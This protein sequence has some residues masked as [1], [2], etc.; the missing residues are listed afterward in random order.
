MTENPFNEQNGEAQPDFNHNE[1]ESPD[2]DLSD[3]NPDDLEF[4]AEARDVPPP[5]PT[6]AF[7]AEPATAVAAPARRGRASLKDEA[8][9]LFCGM[10]AS[11]FYSGR[12]V[13]KSA[14]ICTS[15]RREG[16]STIACGLA[17]AG[18]GPAGGERVAL[19]DFNLRNPS[20]HD[21]LG[22]RSSPG[23]VEAL[24]D[25]QS[26]ASVAQSVNNNLDVFTVG[27]IAQRSLDVLRSDAVERFFQT[28]RETYDRILVDAAPANHYPDAQVLGGVLK[29]VVLVAHCDQT[30]R[31]AIAQAKKRVEAG[32]G[33]V[34]GLVLN[35]RTYPIPGFLYRL[36]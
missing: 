18:S 2:F 32:G 16:A 27:A 21:L 1:K 26:L 24:A 30:P 36:V 34:V 22:L 23:L 35:L 29:D 4:P 13:G 7:A 17:L 19:V 15:A 10:W 3:F 9:D 25:G 11:L 14:L 28:L 5:T 8:E 33:R 20:V 12:T 31:E 6:Q